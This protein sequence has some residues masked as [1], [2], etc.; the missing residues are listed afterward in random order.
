MPVEYK[1]GREG[2]ASTARMLEPGGKPLSRECASLLPEEE[3]SIG[4]L[5]VSGIA[6]DVEDV[7]RF[8]ANYYGVPHHS[9][10]SIFYRTILARPWTTFIVPAGEMEVLFKEKLR[11]MLKQ[12]PQLQAAVGQNLP[13]KGRVPS[14][15]ELVSPEAIGKRLGPIFGPQLKELEESRKALIRRVKKGLTDIIMA[16]EDDEPEDNE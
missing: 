16:D 1:K 15:V 6:D 13:D 14:L 5:Y 9:I 3:R 12:N 10:I 2:I 7:V 11:E 4:T 8:W